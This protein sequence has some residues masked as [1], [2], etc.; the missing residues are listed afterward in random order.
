MA[1]YAYRCRHDHSFDVALPIGSAPPQVTC[2][3]CGTD[4][5]RVYTAPMVAGISAGMAALHQLEDRSRHEPAV[6]GAP[7]GVTRR[8]QPVSRNP[9]HANLPR[10]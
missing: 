3:A 7:A 4:A 8:R 6:V 5:D 10:P 2:D 1:T 9:L